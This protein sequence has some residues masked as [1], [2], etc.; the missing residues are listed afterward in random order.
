MAIPSVSNGAA[1][2]IGPR[3][4]VLS[5]KTSWKLEHDSD[6][7]IIDIRHDVVEINLKD[8]ITSSLR[9]QSGAKS[10]PTLLLYDERG[11]QLFE[12]V[13]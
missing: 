12:E 13:S 4:N 2:I 6:I 10:M 9:P 5:S 11:L 8:E 3:P 7:D 1:E